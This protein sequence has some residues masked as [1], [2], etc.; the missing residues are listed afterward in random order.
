MKQL[1]IGVLAHVDAGKT[2]LSEALLYTAGAIPT[3]G[4]V[5]HRDAHLDTHDLERAR[6]IT[7]FSKQ[8]LFRTERM[9]VTLLDTPGHVDFSTEMERTLQVL[10]YAILVISA[11]DGVQAHTETLWRLLRRSQIPTFLFVTKMDLPNPGREALLA[12]LQKHLDEGC[13]DFTHRDEAWAEA[14]ALREERL[15]E[16]YL[17][18]GTLSPRDV[19][20]L[21]RLG[22]VTPVFFGSA[23]HLEGVEAFLRGLEDFTEAPAYGEDF[24]A[25][26]FK[27]ARDSQGARL[28]YVKLTGGTLSVRAPLIYR[29]LHGEE[30]VE[31]KVTQLRLYSGARFQTAETVSAGQVCAL[32]GLTQ[33]YPGQGLGA[34]SPA[35][36][37]L[38]EPVVTYRL[39]LPEGCDP[40]LLLP[41]LRQLE[42]E[43]PQLHLVW[44]QEHQEIHAR[45]MGQVQIEI[46]KSLID[47]R[48]GVAVQVDQGRILYKETIAA[49][50]EGVGH[51]EPLRHYAEVHLLLE[52]LP[53]GAGLELAT[54]CSEDVLAGH[55]QRLILTHL[56]ERT[57]R[58]VL[59]GAPI[60]DLRITLM[61]GRAH[62]KHTEGGDFR[63]ATYRAVRQGL[64]GAQSVLLE[65]W[66]AFTLTL[67]ADQLGRAISDLQTMG[68]TFSSPESDGE[69][70]TLTGTA[71]VSEMKDYPLTVAAYTRGRGK[72]SCS[73][74]GYAPCHNQKQ[75]VAEA[76]YDPE[77]DLEHSPDSVFCAHGGGFT[78]KWDQVPQYMHLESCLTPDRKAEDPAPVP[79]VFTRNLDIDAKELEAIFQ[80]T[81]G[82][83]RRREYQFLAQ[84]RRPAP[85]VTIAPPKQQYLIVDGYNMIFA[86]DELKDLAKENLDAARQRLMDI[87]SN[88]AGYK[89]CRL[90]LVFDGYKVKGNPG[91]QEDYHH[92]HVVYTR[93]DETGDMFIEKLLQEIGKN[94]AVRVA[95]SDGLIQLSALRAGV[96]RLSAQEL[97]REV[98]WVGRQIDQAVA[99]LNRRGNLAPPP[100]GPAPHGRNR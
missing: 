75:V 2:T 48:F 10:D 40:N 84:E 50:V 26:V 59:T 47:Q 57:H 52:P 32:T 98:E 9:A 44:D 68:G 5:D 62:P 49:P 79:R 6:G 81:F 58:G 22:K 89:G 25:R 53:Q 78:V 43:D 56:A 83:Q 60:T 87:L 46:L 76:G 70:A 93:Q 45:L 34:E 36:P 8:A 69:W 13:V 97:W 86:W 71:P 37:P 80:R 99:E 82:P 17:D 28:T 67:P 51:Y 64:M 35:P 85:E 19:S 15:L 91:T 95:T 72:F 73:L 33:T 39:V 42:E 20:G 1:V 23:L 3:L 55:W 66:Y 61:S 18:T 63:Q 14:V 31:E 4:R 54:R 21:I 41:K 77:R 27:I 92:I 30:D 11:T 24:A 90:V 29:P 100:A 12:E 96:L 7:I 74:H 94:Y 65:P 16:Q 38:L 88:Y